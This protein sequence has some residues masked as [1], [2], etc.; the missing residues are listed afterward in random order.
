[1]VEPPKTP[2]DYSVLTYAWVAFVSALGGVAHFIHKVKTGVAR[3]FNFT[4]LVGELIISAFAGMV[5]FW[6][7]EWA[8]IDPLL[9]AALIAISGH[10]GSRAIFLIEK[11]AE[12]KV[13]N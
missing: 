5:T 12:R 8:R 11:M 13:I 6:L 10:M 1:M 7:C 4:E 3:A 2:F 9:S